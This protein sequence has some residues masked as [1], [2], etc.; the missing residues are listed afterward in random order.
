MASFY[1]DIS[2]MHQ[3]AEEIR[4]RVK[5]YNNAKT[6]MDDIVETLIWS[7]DPVYT[8][9][10]KKYEEEAKIAAENVA[11]LMTQYA[12]LM[13]AMADALDRSQKNALSDIE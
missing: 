5:T 13:G 7:E 10:K 2:R 12:D 6:A 8:A 3:A 4:N 9:Y 1:Y 11:K